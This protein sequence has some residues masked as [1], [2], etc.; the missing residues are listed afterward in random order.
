MGLP[1]ILKAIHLLKVQPGYR[2]VL[3]QVAYVKPFLERYPEEAAAFRQFVAEGR[4]QLV[5][6]MDLMPDVNMPRGE[7]FIRQILYG[8]GSSSTASIASLARRGTLRAPTRRRTSSSSLEHEQYG[9]RQECTEF[10]ITW[11]QPSKSHTATTDRCRRWD[12]FSTARRWNGM[13]PVEA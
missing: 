3:D 2:F 1:N 13:G 11:S 5:L 9:R 8:K 6:G 4:L 7:T 10:N 12:Q